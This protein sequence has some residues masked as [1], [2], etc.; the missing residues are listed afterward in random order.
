MRECLCGDSDRISGRTVMQMKKFR[1]DIVLGECYVAVCDDGIAGVMVVSDIPEKCY[2]EIVGQ[3]SQI[4]SPYITIR[5]LAV[6]ENYRGTNI[7]EKMISFAEK[8]CMETVGSL[9]IRYS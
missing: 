1:H 6:S 3:G 4:D 5:R 9:G 2:E 8:L 7:A